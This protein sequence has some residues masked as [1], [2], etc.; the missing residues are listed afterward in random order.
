MNNPLSMFINA[1][2]KPIGQKLKTKY[3]RG[4]IQEEEG[5][6]IIGMVRRQCTI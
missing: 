3:R 1:T 6:S 5:F 2:L 4:Y